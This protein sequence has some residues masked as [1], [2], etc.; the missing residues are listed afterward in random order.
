M[1]VARASPRRAWV[2]TGAAGK[3][4]MT[5]VSRRRAAAGER[6]VWARRTRAWATSI[7]DSWRT[8]F[9]LSNAVFIAAAIWRIR[10]SGEY[11]ASAAHC[12]NATAAGLISSP[13]DECPRRADS[14]S[15]VPLPTNGSR[16]TA[17]QGASALSSRSTVRGENCPRQGRTLTRSRSSRSR[18]ISVSLSFSGQLVSSAPVGAPSAGGWVSMSTAG[19]KRSRLWFASDG[20]GYAPRPRRRTLEPACRPAAGEAQKRQCR[21]DL[22]E[23]TPR[24]R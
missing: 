10:C 9:V 13:I 5:S 1:P 19:V 14:I 2:G 20:G 22:H 8:R 21:Q 3:D 23:R 4:I 7:L 17:S 6:P 18:S 16:T 12:A 15:A 24:R 11:E